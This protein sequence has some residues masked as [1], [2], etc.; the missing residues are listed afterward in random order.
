MASSEEGA[1][2]L[3]VRSRRSRELL[4][5][6]FWPITIECVALGGDAAVGKTSISC[7]ATPRKR[8]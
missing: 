3:S 5:S 7:V 8:A 6:R 1:T 2:G 4:S